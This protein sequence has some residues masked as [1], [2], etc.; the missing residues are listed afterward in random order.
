M[1]ILYLHA[2]SWRCIT[3]FCLRIEYWYSRRYFQYTTDA[4]STVF[5]YI[6]IFSSSIKLYKH[7]SDTYLFELWVRI[8][9]MDEGKRDVTQVL[10]QWSYLSLA[11]IHWLVT[12]GVFVQ[13]IVLLSSIFSVWSLFTNILQPRPVLKGTV[14][15]VWFLRGQR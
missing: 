8:T 7:S 4:H 6:Y 11:L 9:S 5:V 15:E 3:R 12:C 1:C 2:S 14:I 13:T 10:A